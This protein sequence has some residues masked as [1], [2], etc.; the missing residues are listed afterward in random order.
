MTLPTSPILIPLYWPSWVAS[1]LANCCLQWG[2]IWVGDQSSALLIQLCLG[3]WKDSR[4]C[5]KTGGDC[6]FAKKRRKVVQSVCAVSVDEYMHHMGT[7]CSLEKEMRPSALAFLGGTCITYTC[8]YNFDC[9]DYDW[10]DNARP[11]VVMLLWG[12]G[13]FFLKYVFSTRMWYFW[14]AGMVPKLLGR[15]IPILKL[16]LMLHVL[17][18]CIL[19]WE[20]YPE[21]HVWLWTNSVI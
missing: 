9:L 17:M 15:N 11:V 13:I 10:H 18:S 21:S 16:M 2:S 20:M 12:L 7:I 8:I 19:P 4:C 3:Y 1:L 6:Q 5:T 14:N